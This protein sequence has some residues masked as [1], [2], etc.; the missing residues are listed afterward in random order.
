MRAKPRRDKQDFE[1]WVD[2]PQLCTDEWINVQTF[3]TRAEAIAFA[4]EQFGADD[5]GRVCLVSGFGA[6]ETRGKEQP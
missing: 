5:Q 6:D 1:V 2:I 4:Q 3:T